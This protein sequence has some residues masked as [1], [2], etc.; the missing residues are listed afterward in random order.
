[1]SFPSATNNNLSVWLVLKTD[2]VILTT[3]CLH[4]LAMLNSAHYAFQDQDGLLVHPVVINSLLH[5]NNANASAILTPEKFLTGSNT[6]F[7]E[8]PNPPI[9]ERK[10]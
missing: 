4:I 9:N 1:M 5:T 7:P 6:L 2:R 10:F 8:K 3:S